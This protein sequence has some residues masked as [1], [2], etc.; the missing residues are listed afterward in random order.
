M[1]V[2]CIGIVQALEVVKTH[3]SD[4]LAIDSS[5]CRDQVSMCLHGP[6]GCPNS[7]ASTTC[8]VLAWCIQGDDE[9]FNVQVC[10]TEPRQEPNENHPQALMLSSNSTL[11]NS[12]ITPGAPTTGMC[13][14]RCVPSLTTTRFDSSGTGSTCHLQ[15]SWG[16]AARLLKVIK[17]AAIH[18]WMGPWLIQRHATDPVQPLA[19]QP[20][21]P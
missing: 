10:M 6:T 18:F 2:P 3:L 8:H 5:G 7:L 16:P 9:D 20:L 4:A 13:A 12:E 15:P 14:C 17:A 19:A 21:L 11:H 1:G